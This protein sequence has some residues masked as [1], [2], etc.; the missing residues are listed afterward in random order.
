MPDYLFFRPLEGEFD[1]TQVND[2]LSK[3]GYS[4]RDPVRE[5]LTIVAST[6]EARDY[7][8]SLRTRH[9][10]A[11][12]PYLVLVSVKPNEISVDQM[13]NEKELKLAQ[14]FTQWL[15]EQYR[16]QVEDDYGHD[17]TDVYRRPGGMGT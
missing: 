10:P 14:Q 6:A 13:T 8:L 9:P 5:D 3:L 2:Y 16:C 15:S 17:L 4:V 7:A 12:L 11:N 1:V